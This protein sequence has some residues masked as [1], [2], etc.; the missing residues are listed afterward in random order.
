MK[1]EIYTRSLRTTKTIYGK[2]YALCTIQNHISMNSHVVAAAASS[3]P[4][5][6][7]GNIFKERVERY[8]LLT[9]VGRDIHNTKSQNTLAR[10]RRGRTLSIRMRCAISNVS[11]KLKYNATAQY[12]IK[13]ESGD[14]KLQQASWYVCVWCAL[15]TQT[16][17]VHIL[18][19]PSLHLVDDG[20]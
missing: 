15:G 10:T 5:S 6:I 13:M 16:N 9:D 4:N 12:A 3:E 1:C 18:A 2:W 17:Q 7:W 20:Y 19:P 14:D 8:L 11:T